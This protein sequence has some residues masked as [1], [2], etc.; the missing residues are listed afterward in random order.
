MTKEE[1]TKAANIE[2]IGEYEYKIIE[3]VYTWSPLISETEGKKQV[4]QLYNTFGI[5]IFKD[6]TERA[7]KA[8]ELEGK[9]RKARMEY[10]RL[11]NEYEELRQ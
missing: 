1:F 11:R 2:T 7:K 8:E 9:L 6:M 10:E 5:A 3:Y 4:A